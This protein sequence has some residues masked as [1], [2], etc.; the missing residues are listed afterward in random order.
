MDVENGMGKGGVGRGV[1]AGVVKGKRVVVVV[2]MG[3]MR[4]WE[5]GSRG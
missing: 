4:S 2:I 1:K 5:G 3:R